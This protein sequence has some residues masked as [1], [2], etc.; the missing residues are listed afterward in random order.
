MNS[1]TYTKRCSR[2]FVVAATLNFLPDGDALDV[3]LDNY[4]RYAAGSSVILGYRAV[5]SSNPGGCYSV[6]V[7]DGRIST[8]AAAN[9]TGAVRSGTLQIIDAD[10]AVFKTITLNQAGSVANFVHQKGYS[11]RNLVDGMQSVH[12]ERVVVYMNGGETR[13]LALLEPCY[14]YVQIGRASCRERVLRLV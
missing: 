7:A 3:V 8:V 11:D 12:T 10:G 9:S 13:K 5:L 4:V 6:Q 2:I 1:I 14:D